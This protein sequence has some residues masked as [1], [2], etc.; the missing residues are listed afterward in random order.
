ME[1][2]APSSAPTTAEIDAGLRHI[3]NRRR[4]SHL[5]FAA[6]I[7]GAVCVAL[8]DEMWPG[9]IGTARSLLTPLFL[10]AI[11]LVVFVPIAGLRCPR[12]HGF[13]HAG[14]KY[15]NDFVRKCLHCGLRLNGSNSR[16]AV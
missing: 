4:L 1:R 16:D 5:P 9:A 13:F 7:I 10:V 14:P 6:A 15:R 3:R 12:C 11:L 2:Q 8:A